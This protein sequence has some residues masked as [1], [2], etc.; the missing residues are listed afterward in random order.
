MRVVYFLIYL[1]LCLSCQQRS[2]ERI[3]Q[4]EYI[5]ISDFE[6]LE[7]DSVKVPFISNV[8]DLYI[9]DSMLIIKNTSGEHKYQLL[10]SK[11][12]SSI[13]EF[14]KIGNGPNEFTYPEFVRNSD[15]ICI[16]DKSK[17]NMLFFDSLLNVES[18][19]RIKNDYLMSSIKSLT[20]SMYS[21][22]QY[23]PQSSILYFTNICT[24]AIS[25][26]LLFELSGDRNDLK[27]FNYEMVE[28]QLFV[29]FMYSDLI[30]VYDRDS[31]SKTYTLSKEIT[32]SKPQIN[33]SGKVYYN[34]M[35]CVNSKMYILNQKNI[36]VDE[37]VGTING[38]T[39]ILVFSH[40]GA[41]EKEIRLNRFVTHM[42]VDQ[43]NEKFIF[44]SPLNDNYL[45]EANYRF[46]D[47]AS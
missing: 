16:V 21:F 33:K 18:Q 27:E 39:S 19:I 20:D 2:S 9:Q 4:K 34:D 12:Y 24:G 31:L 26:S 13:R 32:S 28:N 17:N 7:T 22:I 10:Q 46:L 30:Y 44:Y 47:S 3:V 38:E 35:V 15:R 1:V 6:Y 41:F 43:T 14:G 11:N 29:S 42:V 40:L 5:T 8:D 23:T 25:D 37:E 36:E 45:F